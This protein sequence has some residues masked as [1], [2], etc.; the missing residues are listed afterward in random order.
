MLVTQFEPADG[1]RFAP[2]WDEPGAKATFTLA[3]VTPK[4]PEQLFQHADRAH[5]QAP[6]RQDAGHLPAESEDVELSAVPGAGS[7]WSGAR[8]WSGATEIGVITRRGALDQADYA[9]D[10]GGAAAAL[11]QRLFRRRPIRCPS[12]T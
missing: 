3:A 2:M 1:R 11:F 9:L 6:G 4:G 12:S 10:A 5:R 8:G 7:R